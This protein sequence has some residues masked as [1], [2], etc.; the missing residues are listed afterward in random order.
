[1][2]DYIGIYKT[3]IVQLIFT[4]TKQHNLK[5]IIK[6]MNLRFLGNLFITS[7]ML[8]FIPYFAFG[9]YISRDNYTG[10]FTDT[11]SWTGGVAPNPANVN[12]NTDIYGFITC[13]AD[14]EISG[15]VNLTVN[16]TLVV[17]GNLVLQ[18]KANLTISNGAICIINGN[19]TAVNKLNLDFGSHF[20]VTGNFTA[21]ENQTDVT[22][23]EGAAIYILGTVDA[24]NL[25][26]FNCDNSSGYIP[27]GSDVGCRYGDIISLED[28]EN[29]YS[30]I[31]DF[32]V[33]SDSLMG[34]NPV[35]TELCNDLE[36]NISVLF[37]DGTNYTWYDS[38]GTTVVGYGTTLTTNEPGEY[39]ATYTYNSTTITTYRVRVTSSN[40]SE[41]INVTNVS[42]PGNSDGIISI[43][44]PSGGSGTY[45]YSIYGDSAWQSSASFTG[46][47]VGYY[48]VRI[49]DAVSL[50][51]KILSD[52]IEVNN[53]DTIL[54]TIICPENITVTV[55]SGT[56]VA[57]GISLGNPVT[58]DNCGIASVAN[59][60][61]EPYS[62]GNTIVTW[63]A[64]DTT[65]N[66]ATCPQ[67]VT[68]EP[69]E[70]IDVGVD[71]LENSC[72]SGETGTQT[73]ITWNIIKFSGVDNWSFD[74]VISDG[75]SDV[76]SGTKSGLT[77]SGTQLS[78][79][80]NNST[81][82]DQTYTL[83][84]TNVQD[85]CTTEQN[86]TNNSDSVILWG[87]PDTGEIIPD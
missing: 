22:F 74:Y 6:F 10:T 21:S 81:G 56:C 35:Y 28:N 63:S 4:L 38:L 65:G 20:I 54:P 13:N 83:T 61:A 15:N 75:L 3:I 12:N 45:E 67:I 34:V 78:F 24:G 70:T 72:Q 1:L 59:N 25:L 46:L 79:T 18:N 66:I 5:G 68:V 47:S 76:D 50:C 85:N 23:S 16:D 62:I 84:L 30:G 57:T 29:T 71:N 31:Y 27:P 86:T 44:N 19:V 69:E 9:Q 87:V 77:G 17:N 58:S 43:L 32:I 52:S 37:T 53:S 2:F 80:F 39:F 51:F 8:V 48:D 49:R 40:L 36:A 33:G 60:A 7:L 73:I 14:L 26:G 41:D 55:D 64:Q 42:C 82:I 11:N